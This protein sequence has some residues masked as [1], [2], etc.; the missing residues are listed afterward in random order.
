MRKESEAQRTSNLKYR[1]NH[2]HTLLMNFPNSKY[3]I[4]DAYCK[5]INSPV[6]TWVRGLIWNAID[7]DKT[8]NYIPNDD[9]EVK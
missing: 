5:H 2:T 1:K 4:I 9:K 8:F 3:D 7:S 6:A